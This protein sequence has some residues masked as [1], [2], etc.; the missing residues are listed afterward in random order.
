MMDTNTKDVWTV[1][2]EV[3]AKFTC[4]VDLYKW[5][6]NFERGQTP[7]TALLDI[8][9]WSKEQYGENLYD[10]NNVAMGY[11]DLGLLADA[12]TLYSDDPVGTTKVIETIL[13]A[14]AQ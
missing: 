10:W 6:T 5:S 2:D 9:G 8:I 13:E 3:E 12:I 7:M 1:L 11:Y 14:E 4:I